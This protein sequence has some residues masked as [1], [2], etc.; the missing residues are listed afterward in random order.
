MSTNTGGVRARELRYTGW[1]AFTSA[2]L[3][4]GIMPLTI[5]RL[6]DLFPRWSYTATE[7]AS[8]FDRYRV[9]V[10]VQ[11]VASTPTLVV[12]IWQSIVLARL[13]DAAG[14]DKVAS[15]VMVTMFVAYSIGIL[16]ARTRGRTADALEATRDVS[17]GR[18]NPL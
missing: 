8:W 11:I 3:L 14:G 12:M 9:A 15:R 4:V 7:L 2:L 13:F 16:L 1:A 10:I 17:A 6:P 5:D 18:E